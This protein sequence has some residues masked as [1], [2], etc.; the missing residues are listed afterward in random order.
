[1][2][3]PASTIELRRARAQAARADA[4]AG[5]LKCDMMTPTE[6]RHTMTSPASTI[7][8]RRAR[9]QAARADAGAGFVRAAAAGI[10]LVKSVI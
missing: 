3:S 7:E 8:L 4:G 10:V 9:A 5:W 2:T 6:N 1:M